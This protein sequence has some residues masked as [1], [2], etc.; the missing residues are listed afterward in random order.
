ME[1]KLASIKSDVQ[2]LER[3]GS[4]GFPPLSAVILIKWLS[5]L[6]IGFFFVYPIIRLLLL[7]VETNQGWSGVHF[8]EVLRDQRTWLALDNTLWAVAGSTVLSLVIGVGLAWICAYTDIRG[9]GWI[10][11]LALMPFII[12]SY[13][14]TLAWTQL[15]G[16]TGLLNKWAAQ[17]A[18]EH[19]VLWNVYGLDGIIVLMGLSHYPL[20]YLLTLAV[21]YRIPRDLEWAARSS[22]AR[23]WQVFAKVTLPLALPG[24]AGGGLLAFVSSL[25]NFGIPAF[26]GIPEGISVISTLIYEQVAGF[27]PDA[28]SRAAVLS[29]LL[30]T[31]AL[32]GSGLQW[33]IVRRAKAD[34]TQ[35]DDKSVRFSLGRRRIWVESLVWGFLLLTSIVPFFAMFHTALIRAYGLPF[36]PENVTLDNFWFV[37]AGNQSTKQAILNS[38]MLAG[39]TTLICVVVGTLLAYWRIK[40]RDTLA[41]GLEGAV[42]VPYALPGMVLGLA[43]ILTWIE[44]LPGWSP[45]VYGTIWLILIA[46][47]TRFLILQVKSSA[48]TILQVHHEVEEAARING[49]GRLARWRSVLLPL[50][51]P[52]MLTG[53]FLVFL[54]SLSELTVSSLLW[55]SGAETIGVMIFSLEQ[56]GSTVYST[57]F[58]TLLVLLIGM[59]IAGGYWLRQRW[60]RRGSHE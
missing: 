40:S 56:A 25:D 11:L 48:S 28:F 3:R 47:V 37:I 49:A 20:V 21:L 14:T 12:P 53:A 43:M 41:K 46:Y 30:G 59:A 18:G 22:G 44:P 29:T 31:V 1:T 52:G 58:S 38:L 7:S 55:S 60:E 19:L 8:A 26:L 42:S 4:W 2:S 32:A 54:T 9:K 50:Y 34:H 24:I 35:S 51:L 45:G 27:G 16:P 13:I 6:V 39:L 15:A 36:T 33:L 10:H 57:A 17:L 23:Q 5:T